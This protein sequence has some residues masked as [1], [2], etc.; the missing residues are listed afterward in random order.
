M[1]SARCNAGALLSHR[2][3]LS[4]P[5]E[6]FASTASSS[7]V[8]CASGLDFV[9]LQHASSMR[10]ASSTCEMIKTSGL[11]HPYQTSSHVTIFPIPTLRNPCADYPF[12]ALI[13]F[14]TAFRQIR[15]STESPRWVYDTY[16]PLHLGASSLASC[17]LCDIGLLDFGL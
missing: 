9:R 14:R 8:I 4:R 15:A 16:T 13:L 2:R 6:N 12:F 1:T 11:F 7:A 3:S 5:P 10:P 17:A